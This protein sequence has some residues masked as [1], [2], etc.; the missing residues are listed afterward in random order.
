MS[1]VPKPDLNRAESDSGNAPGSVNVFCDN[2][3]VIDLKSTLKRSVRC[4]HI[5]SYA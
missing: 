4:R 1:V 2:T 3:E 5:Y